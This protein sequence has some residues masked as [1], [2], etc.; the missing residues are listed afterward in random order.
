MAALEA[1]VAQLKEA[2]GG[3]AAQTALPARV[4]RAEADIA[5]VASEAAELRTAFFA[6]KS[7]KAPEVDS[8]IIA[9]FPPLFNEFHRKRSKLLWRSS[10]DYFHAKEFH[11]RCD[12][13]A[14]T[15]TLI[16]DIEGNVFGGFTPMDWESRVWNGWA[17]MTTTATRATTACG[18]S[19]SR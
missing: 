2:A 3:I 14:N 19:S 6:L 7:W 18:V 17:K 11:R 1:E 9:E 15:L 13:R 4:H 16:A 12:G 8:V 5:R 10:R